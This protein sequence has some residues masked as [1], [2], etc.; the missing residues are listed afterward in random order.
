MKT[1]KTIYQ[2]KINRTDTQ[3]EAILAKPIESLDINV[4]AQP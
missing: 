3:K 4:T 1:D 2:G